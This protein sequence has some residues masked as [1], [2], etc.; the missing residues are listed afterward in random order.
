MGAQGYQRFTDYVCSRSEL[1]AL[2]AVS[3][4]RVII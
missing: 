4:D 1:I 2:H 3:A